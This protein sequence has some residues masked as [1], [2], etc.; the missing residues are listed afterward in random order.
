MSLVKTETPGYIRDTKTGAILNTNDLEYQSILKA[1]REAKKGQAICQR[2]NTL[3]EELR[4][5]KDMLR[6]VVGKIQ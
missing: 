3:E 4:E 1:R 5:I 2:M 6:Q